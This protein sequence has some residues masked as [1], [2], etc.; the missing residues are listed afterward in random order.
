MQQL[1]SKNYSSVQVILRDETIIMPA[2]KGELLMEYLTGDNQ[3]SH[4][5]LTD[6]KGNKS[7]V[8]KNDIR[9]V[10]PVLNTV[11]NHFKSPEELG[12]EKDNRTNTA[13]GY[14]KFQELKSKMTI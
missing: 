4:V 6:T 8:N 13:D 9:K 12:M 10:T 3:S 7:V 11:K 1:D 5:M 2:G 14:K